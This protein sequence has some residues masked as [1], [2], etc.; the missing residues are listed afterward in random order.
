MNLFIEIEVYDREFKSRLLL[1]SEAST[2]GFIVYLLSRHEMINLLNR[3]KLP[4]GI[5]HLKDANCSKENIIIYKKLKELGFLITAQDEES[6]IP[7]DNYIDFI[8]RRFSSGRAFNF[9]D[10]FFC[11]GKRDLNILNKKF[12][13]KIFVITGS[14]RF[15][16]CNQNFYEKK[17]SFLIK[18]KLKRF[19]LISSN[20]QYPIGWRT[21]AAQYNSRLN[22]ESENEDIVIYKQKNFFEKFRQNLEQIPYFINLII[23]LSFHLK[24]LDI[25]L[26]PHPNEEIST[27][28]ILLR[29]IKNKRNVKIIKSGTLVEFINFSECLIQS[30]C[31]AAI[32]ACINKKKIISFIPKEYEDS[33][34][35]DFVN[36]LGKK[37]YNEKE[38]LNLINK[39]EFSKNTNLNKINSRVETMP[40]NKFSFQKIVEIWCQIYRDKN[41]SKIN[42]YYK[43]EIFLFIKNCF[44][45]L[46][47]FFKKFIF[48]SKKQN[49][50]EKFPDYNKDLIARNFND[51]IR[52]DEKYKNIKFQIL[53]N[54][55][56]KVY[57]VRKFN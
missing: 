38:V 26:R 5:Y 31:T 52:F 42:N 47:K 25:V 29:R 6:G 48:I 32:E 21:L 12:K 23:Y 15:D 37:A 18:N 55:V 17:K 43:L 44:Y 50:F 30:G 2:K 40:S 28:H 4:V 14:P 16:L 7:Y 8:K 19:V 53:S 56:L 20:I 22:Q 51:F 34:D 39:Q 57:C 1:A 46:K 13:K 9:F 24:G 10:K 49:T 33:F 3:K 45:N 41:N 36:S 54:K 35:A 27:W 11:Y